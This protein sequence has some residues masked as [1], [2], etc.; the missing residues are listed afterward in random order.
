MQTSFI[1]INSYQATIIKINYQTRHHFKGLYH[2]L[3]NH[4]FY[5]IFTVGA[6]KIS[7]SY[8][9][10]K[11]GI[12]RLSFSIV[13][14]SN[15]IFSTVCLIRATNAS[16]TT[17]NEKGAIGSPYY[18]PLEFLNSII[19]ELFTNTKREKDS[20]QPLMHCIHLW[21]NLI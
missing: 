16:T 15:T 8:A 4:H 12:C 14:P 21:H 3:Q 2:R 5:F 13:T 17:R 7:G 6:P 9:Y 20:I 10:Y 18:R 19:W 1:H 11:L